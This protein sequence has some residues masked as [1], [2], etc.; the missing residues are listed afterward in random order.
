MLRYLFVLS[1]YDTVSTYSN[2]VGHSC[3]FLGIFQMR[4]FVLLADEECQYKTR[5]EG[6]RNES[7]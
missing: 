2:G 4:V 6:E 1:E 5:N 3:L 7:L